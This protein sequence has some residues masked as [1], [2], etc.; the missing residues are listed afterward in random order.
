MQLHALLVFISFLF[1]L[2]LPNNALAN[3]SR[4][5]RKADKL[6]AEQKYQEAYSAYE[7]IAK[8]G[9]N[10]P[11]LINLALF[12]E[13]GW[14]RQTDMVKA[15]QWYT[16]AAELEVPLALDK[17]AHCFAKGIHQAIDIQR[18]VHLYEKA[19]ELGFHLSLCHLGRLYLHGEGVQQNSQKGLELCA[20]AAEQGSIPAMLQIADFNLALNTQESNASALH[21]YSNAASYRSAHAQFKIGLMLRD[22]QGLKQDPLEAREWFEKAAAQGYQPA[23]FETAALYY[24][25]PKDPATNLWLEQ[26]LAKSY[27]W[28]SAA[29][30]RTN[31]ALQKNQLLAML[32]E[33]KKVMPAT[34]ENELN[35]KLEAHLTQFPL[36]AN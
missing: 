24:A 14:G 2:G 21:W 22:G 13:L 17:S 8:E 28:I 15:C 27:L 5:L 7:N 6:L 36:L 9:N 35:K 16:K 33:V 1:C 31:N 4:E 10:A 11:A 32:T 20:Q 30:Q 12:N 29:L 19:A 3:E 18:A 23:Y 34:W 26:D 25:A